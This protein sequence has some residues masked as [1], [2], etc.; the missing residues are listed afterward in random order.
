MVSERSNQAKA[1][2]EQIV[3]SVTPNK[4]QA[5]LQLNPPSEGA[6]WPTY[7]EIINFLNSEGVVFGLKEQ[8]IH[9]LLEEK[10]SKS[11]LI[12]EGEYPVKG[13]DAELKFYFETDRIRLIPKELED[14]RV[15]HRELSMLQNV[16]K[17]QVLV[18][19]KPATS[20]ISGRNVLGEEIKAPQGKDKTL[21]L[22]KNV[23]WDQN[24]IIA[25]CDGEPTLHNRKISVQVV[26]EI[27][28]NVGYKTGNID[29]VGSVH[30]RGDVENGFTVKAAGDVVISGN[31]EG[32]FIYADG[33]ITINGGIIGQ[34]KSVISAKGNLYA[35]YIDHAKVNVEGEIKV[36]DA[37]LHSYINCGRKITLGTRKGLV[38]GGVVRAGESIDA[39]F[40]GSKMGTQTEVEVGTNPSN[41]LELNE[42]EK[43]L[44]ELAKELD[45]V[46]KI[47]AILN[48]PGYNL[49]PEREELRAKSTRTSFVL[50]AEKRR[51][52]Q[53]RDEIIELLNKRQIERGYVKIR[54]TIYPGVKVVI[55]KAIR[56]FKDEL[57]FAMLAYD[58]GE[59][60]IQPYR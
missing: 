43:R 7:E 40:L 20:G 23:A 57:N 29:F 58:E 35:R 30:I 11:T 51:L 37:I 19:K 47:L 22:G 55:G 10:S 4:M 14:G 42:I 24:R 27:H 26:H 12:A 36:R 25:T 13:E 3:L 49:T 39:Q 2:T 1:G 45:S 54:Q 9:R 60:S 41:R 34:D 8:V 59:I 16:Q 31:V 52:E 6:A 38:L 48:K 18:E 21:V 32:G 28:G 15:D 33:D 56:I 17:G 5:Y 46:E 50:K 44:A 53:R